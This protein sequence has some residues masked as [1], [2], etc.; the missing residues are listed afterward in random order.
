MFTG[1]VTERGKIVRAESTGGGLRLTI[2][3]PASAA[4]L[5][6]NDSV[7]VNGA[8]QTV[9]RTEGETFDVEAM[10]ETLRKTTLGGLKPGADVNLEL[11]LKMEDR[12]GGHV[13]LGHVDTTGTIASRQ[14]LESSTIF[15]IDVP[16]EFSK[17]IVP[18]GSIAVDGVS[19]TIARVERNSFDV[20]I[21]PHTMEKTGFAS[22]RPG[23]PVNLEFDI[24]GK[25][26]ERLLHRENEDRPQREPL[27][28]KALRELGY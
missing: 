1:I 7:S 27:T 25:Y 14:A 24:I 6:V 23:D 9:I 26:V 13:V 28:E 17:Y 11:P 20:S 3:A 8:C 12:L 5:S 2:H 18:V 21:I 22:L 15:R 10:E 4:E 19:L 16:A